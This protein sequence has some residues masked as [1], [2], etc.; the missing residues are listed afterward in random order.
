VSRGLHVVL[1]AILALGTAACATAPEATLYQALGERAG[2]EALVD[3][4][5]YSLASNERA[6]PLFRNTNIQRFREQFALQ[7]C[8]VSD[9]PCDY[10]GDSMRATHKGMAIS[11]AQFNSVVE[12]LIAAMERR[13]LLTATQNALLARLAPLY[14][15]IT[16]L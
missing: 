6:R 8:E 4:F 1:A 10:T 11:R 15:E 3:E 13:D 16:G 12:D 2:I 7:L 9:G 5:L 14:P